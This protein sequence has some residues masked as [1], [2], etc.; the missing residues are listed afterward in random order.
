MEK[1]INAKTTCSVRIITLQPLSLFF[2]HPSSL[3][4][5]WLLICLA[6]QNVATW[7]HIQHILKIVLQWCMVHYLKPQEGQNI[8]LSISAPDNDKKEYNSDR[9]IYDPDK[10]LRK[11]GT[12][13]WDALSGFARDLLHV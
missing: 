8:V 5:A 2:Y 1:V 9:P 12:L 10:L 4:V 7:L 3:I 13:P 6:L 11:K